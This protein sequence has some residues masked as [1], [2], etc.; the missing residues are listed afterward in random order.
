LANVAFLVL[1]VNIG[2]FGGWDL[3]YLI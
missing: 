3:E 2:M 1:S